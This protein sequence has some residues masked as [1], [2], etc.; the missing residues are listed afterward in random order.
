MATTTPEAP[1]PNPAPAGG[2]AVSH[3]LA[4]LRPWIEYVPKRQRR[5]GLFL[6]LAFFVQVATFFFIRID[7]TRA[8]LRH[9]PRLH[10]AV[11]SPQATSF[12]GREND[13]FWDRLTD[14]RLFLFPATTGDDDSATPAVDLAALSPDM[15]TRDLPPPAAPE[16]AHA[17]SSTIAPVEQR[18]EASLRPARQPFI[19]DENAP[20]ISP[21][22]TWVW[23]HSLD[24]RQPWN[25]PVLP[26][27]VS[28]T[29]LSPTVLRVA[30]DPSG[31]VQHVLV[32]QSSGDQ[33]APSG[34]DLDEKAVQAAQKIRF[35][36]V[37]RPGLEWG[38]LTVFWH[39]S[40]KPREEVVPT[41]PSGP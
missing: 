6:A 21:Y 28:D 25:V 19:Y 24:A 36:P 27:P 2:D 14:P 17:A 20:A 35:L 16:D 11:Q 39:Y 40:A 23:D 12:D 37:D 10:V 31:T 3:T 41:P 9:Q 15:A 13:G 7:N 26:S 34:R 5:L 1:A 38:L 29:D 22:T 8:E 30:I 33:G 4:V 32:E 18:V